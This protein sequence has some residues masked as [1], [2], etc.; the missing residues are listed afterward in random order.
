MVKKKKE[1]PDKGKNANKQPKPIESNDQE[2][3]FDFGGLPKINLKK[4]LGC[5]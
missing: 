5:G 3:R 4:N 2:D 1:K